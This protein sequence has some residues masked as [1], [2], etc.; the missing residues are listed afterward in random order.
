MEDINATM[1]P[2][3]AIGSWIRDNRTAGAEEGDVEHEFTDWIS[4]EEVRT[5]VA[6][7]NMKKAPGMDGVPIIAIKELANLD[8]PRLCAVYNGCLL[9]GDMP[10]QWKK[11]R[12]VLTS[13]PGKDPTTPEAYRPLCIIDGIAK[14]FEHIVKNRLMDAVVKGGFVKN[15]IQGGKV[16]G[17]MER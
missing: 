16:C 4:E 2:G 17:Q 1:R 6:R 14:I 5:A 13:K 15:V 11:T 8:M 12:L 9:M 10:A 3:R 7:L